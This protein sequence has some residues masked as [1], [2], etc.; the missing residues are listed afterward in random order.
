MMT[1]GY[2]PLGAD[3]TIANPST[4]F[5]FRNDSQ[6]PV[7]IEAYTSGTMLYVNIYGKEVRPENRTIE[8]VTVTE[9]TVLPGAD[10]VTYDSERD[11]DYFYVAQNAHTGYTAAFYKNIYVDGHLTEQILV[12][13]SIYGAYPR[14]V[15]RGSG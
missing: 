11:A 15:V 10:V 4:D 13:R 6:T 7:L 3:A 9:E 2:V 1:V 12:N 14:Y 8:F 5:K